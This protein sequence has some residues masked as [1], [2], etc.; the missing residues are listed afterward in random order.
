[1]ESSTETG[2]G[3]PP[4]AVL[5]GDY[6]GV[7]PIAGVERREHFHHC[8]RA[9]AIR[10]HDHALR[11][12]RKRHPCSRHAGHCRRVARGGAGEQPLS[13]RAAEPWQTRFKAGAAT[14][15]GR[16][17]W[18]LAFEPEDPVP[19]VALRPDEAVIV[20]ENK[21]NQPKELWR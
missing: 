20:F 9:D 1:M 4:R 21:T 12:V 19:S 15:D 10:H 11:G 18:N 5:Q 16:N 17:G 7:A 13:A 6:L 2:L 8:S 3:G 14:A